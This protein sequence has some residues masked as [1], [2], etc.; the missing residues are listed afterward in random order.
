MSI[1]SKYAYR[2]STE[3]YDQR[4]KRSIVSQSNYMASQDYTKRNSDYK[5]VQG[6]F[7]LRRSSIVDYDAGTQSQKQFARNSSP[8]KYR[9]TG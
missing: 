8:L 4:V 3:L 9:N 6:D 5:K 1:Y 7:R 2:N